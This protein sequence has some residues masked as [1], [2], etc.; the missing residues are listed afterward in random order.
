MAAA[1]VEASVREPSKT[2]PTRWKR[3]RD[4]LSYA[5]VSAVVLLPMR[6]LWRAPG[7]PMEEGFMLV[8]PEE[9]LHGAIP[10]RDFL[11]LYGPGSVWVLAGVFKVFG[12][13]IWTERAVGLT[14]QLAL[15]AAVYA[16]TRPW[17]RR[18]AT[19]GAA[20]TAVI[21]LPPTGLTAMAWVGG[22]ALGLW[23]M[24]AALRGRVLLAGLLA[25]AALLYRPDLVI[26]VVLGLA[27][28]WAALTRDQ[29][30]RM[31][32]GAALGLSPFLVHVALAGPGHAFFGMVLQ[33]VFQL[34]A[35]RHLPLPPSWSQFDGF[36]QRAGELNA[37]GWPIEWPPRPAQL[38]LWLFALVAVAAF[39]AVVGWRVRR[40][41]PI[42][43]S[44][45]AVLVMGAYSV[46]LLPQALQRPD[47]T[48]LAWVGAVPFGLLP[49][50]IAEVLRARSGAT[51]SRGTRL[52]V[53]AAAPSLLLIAIVPHFTFN[54][55]TDVVAQTFDRHREVYVMHNEGRSFYYG[56]RDAA[57]AVNAML[58]VVD[59]L[60]KPGDKLFV[61]TGDLRKTPYSEA[62]LYYL[63]PQTRPGT[64]Y[65][66]MD[67]GVANRKDSGLADDLAASDLVI[68]SSIRDDWNEPNA[69]LD[70]GSDQAVQVLQQQ[71]CMVG[72][73]GK[74]LFGRGLYELYKRC[75]A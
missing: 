37:Q 35:G 8:F 20:I 30:R 46:G 42:S 66:E 31:L 6:G 60:A 45:C 44:T 50:A 64:R 29:R 24:F 19:G 41:G 5:L 25:G 18:V 73:W 9:V 4:W 43:L 10:N 12:T 62:Y 7:P 74:G 70:V 48:H 14:Q 13:S 38:T 32:T 28:L 17:G 67:P 55:Y 16:M 49:V 26:A 51:T 72:S 57:E 2:T 3:G 52:L 65:V 56:R 68:L 53:A 61:G 71:F 33:P 34:R 54:P 21:I 40:R 27:A 39:I 63:L 58:P 1:G 15:I 47:S 59:Q 11:H 36:L 69:S 23:A 22:V 75:D